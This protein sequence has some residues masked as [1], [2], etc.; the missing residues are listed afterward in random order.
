MILLLGSQ[1]CPTNVTHHLGL[2]VLW[3]SGC[4]IITNEGQ[5]W[6]I[7]PLDKGCKYMMR[8][9]TSSNFNHDKILWIT[10]FYILT[11][12]QFHLPPLIYYPF[13]ILRD[14]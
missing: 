1:Q 12:L 13:Y 10:H 8:L 3:H 6:M 11:S 4:P 7:G 14:Y 5:F 9:H 2:L